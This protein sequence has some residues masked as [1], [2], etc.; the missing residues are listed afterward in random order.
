MSVQAMS[1]VIEKSRHKSGELVVLLMIANHAHADGRGSWPSTAT[2]AAESRMTRRQVQRCIRRLE[3][4][5][6][7]ATG[8]NA[9]PG[10]AN[11]YSLPLMARDADFHRGVKM[12]QEG[13]VIRD[14]RGRNP[15][16]EGAT[17]MSPEPS[18]KQPSLK[19]PKP[20]AQTRRA[21]NRFDEELE[22][23]RRIEAR[24]R[25]LFDEDA[26]AREIRVGQGPEERVFR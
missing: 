6:E 15:K 12:S 26:V 17:P 16:Q 21:R 9:G 20:R 3:L 14:A 11:L 22:Q 23:R 25:R 24:D 13:G 1:W 4:S 18:L 7:L 2:L 10:G 8:R 5:G 19:Q